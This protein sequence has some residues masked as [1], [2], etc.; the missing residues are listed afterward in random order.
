MKSKEVAGFKRVKELAEVR[1]RAKGSDRK[2]GEAMLVRGWIEKKRLEMEA[3]L[4]GMTWMEYRYMTP[5]ERTEL[6]T[7]E[8]HKAYLA[9]Y[10][11]AYPDEDVSKKRPINPVFAA[12]DIGIM[13]AL[14]NARSCA[15]YAGVPYDVYLEIVIESHLV[16]D[17]WKRP[18]RPNQ[19]Y[20]K[21]A[22]PRLQEMPTPELVEERLFGSNWNRNFFAEADRGDEV[23]ASAHRMLKTVVDAAIDPAKKLS[24]YLCERKAITVERAKLTFGEELVSTARTLSNETPVESANPTS[25]YI[26]ACLGYPDVDE[27]SACETCL[28]NR[29]CLAFHRIVREEMV[30]TLGT[31]DPRRDWKKA[32]N[33]NRQRRF[34]ERQKETSWTSLV[35]ESDRNPD[36]NTEHG[37]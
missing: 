33:R 29:Q 9:A 27:I 2:M 23:Q 31:D 14:W 25:K 32:V 12:N 15:D 21:L 8:Y 35:D 36:N 28:V 20:G 4:Q 34:R 11:K 6:F 17:K 30:R 16:N 19:L 24:E 7:K 1:A 10:A 22:L 18:P 13:N 37:H 26:P 3:D 5:L